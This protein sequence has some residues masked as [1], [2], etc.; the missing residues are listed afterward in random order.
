MK[1]WVTA[2]VAAA[3]IAGT[4][5][6]AFAKWPNDRVMT[7]V[8]PYPAGT[9]VDLIARVLADSLSKKWGN[10]V[11]V[12]N[13]SG[14]AGTIAQSF[15]AKARPDGYT[16]A[17]NTPSGAANAKLIYQAL[18]YDPLTDFSFIMRLTEDAMVLY[19]GPRL[20]ATNLQEFAAYAK[21]NPGKIQFGNPGVGT[22]SQMTQLA[23]QDLL[24]VTFNL[25]QYRG[26]PQMITDLLG[27]QIDAVIDLTGG[28]L[29][30][31]QSGSLHALAVFGTHPDPRLPGVRTAIDQ[32]TNFA[33]EAW[34]GMEGPKGLPADIVKQLNETVTDILL[35][36]EAA[37]TK[38]L[39]IG[40]TPNPSTP[41]EFATIVKNE[42]EKWRPIVTK[43]DI[44]AE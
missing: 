20:K 25:V 10:N 21:A 39:S 17:V 28:Y 5:A 32:G 30:Q 7:F 41:E 43:Y 14:A 9:G 33:V 16:I 24:G 34:Y 12:E 44:H 29:P 13:K 40:S 18:P 6:N 3:C 1:T 8:V 27:R 11:I 19:A 31:I 36:D 23:L 2:F 37:R 15:V 22:Y 26:A 38:I 42:I 35:H 4:A